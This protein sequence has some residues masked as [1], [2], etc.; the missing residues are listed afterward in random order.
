MG[1]PIEIEQIGEASERSG[2]EAPVDFGVE[3]AEGE[4]DPFEGTDQRRI[5]GG[6][7]AVG[8]AGLLAASDRCASL[9]YTW[10]PRLLRGREDRVG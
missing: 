3:R 4:T 6:A 1:R 8:T 2:G 10:R 5:E 9:V 7:R